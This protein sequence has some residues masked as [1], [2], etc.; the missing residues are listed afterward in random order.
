MKKSKYAYCESCDKDVRFNII[1]QE[2][3]SEYRGVHY[4]FL[5]KKAVCKH[6]GE[7]VYPVSVG[8]ENEI[9]LRDA[10]KKAA[11]L[12][13]SKEIIEIRKKLGLSQEGLARLIH[14]GVKN[15]ARYETG[16]IQIR[17]IDNAIRELVNVKEEKDLN[18]QF[19]NYLSKAMKEKNISSSELSKLTQIKTEEIENIKNGLGNPTFNKANKLIKALGISF[20]LTL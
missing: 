11:G 12:L 13:T 15:I 1:E 14:C 2:I 19:G 7:H 16:A 18:E 5:Y 8:R 3:K 9:S 20:R 10:Y 4:T 6:C 17:S